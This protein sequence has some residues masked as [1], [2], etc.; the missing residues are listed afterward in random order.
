MTFPISEAT[1]KTL[2]RQYSFDMDDSPDRGLSKSPT[3]QMEVP[4][5]HMKLVSGGFHKA[6]CSILKQISS[7]EIATINQQ[8][9]TDIVENVSLVSGI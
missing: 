8:A 9:A 1:E 6:Q 7:E 2:K 5:I 3:P 4:D